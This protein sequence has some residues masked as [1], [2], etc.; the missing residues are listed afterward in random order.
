MSIVITA[1]SNHAHD[2]LSITARASEVAA[3]TGLVSAFFAWLTRDK[4][5]AIVAAIIVTELVVAACVLLPIAYGH[6]VARAAEEMGLLLM[7]AAVAFTVPMAA[8]CAFGFVGLANMC[9]RRRDT[10]CNI[11]VPSGD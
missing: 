2:V 8:C 9:F 10:R 11:S 6:N 3:I 1:I 5:M 4:V 7:I